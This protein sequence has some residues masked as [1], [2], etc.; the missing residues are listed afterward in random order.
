MPRRVYL[1]SVYTVTLELTGGS[2]VDDGCAA[3][4]ELSKFIANEVF[5]I[6]NDRTYKAE[7]SAKQVAGPPMPE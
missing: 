6:H 3:A 7:L 5:F 1:P 4:Y 2:T